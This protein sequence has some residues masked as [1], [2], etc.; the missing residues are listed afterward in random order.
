MQILNFTIPKYLRDDPFIISLH[1]Q[2]TKSGVLTKKQTAALED[3]LEIELDFYGWD[4]PVPEENRADFEELLAKFRRNGFRDAKN[5][6]I[7]AMNSII[8]GAPSQSLIDNALDRDFFNSGYNPSNW[9]KICV[10]ID[11]N[12]EMTKMSTEG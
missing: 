1:K 7:R 2:F 8:D 6:C 9:L 4:A 12:T 11:Y 3:A 10:I 5:R